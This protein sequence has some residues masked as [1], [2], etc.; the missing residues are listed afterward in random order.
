M[1]M[2]KII[3]PG[4]Q[5]LGDRTAQLIKISSSGLRGSDLN[6]L[7]KRAGHEFASAIKNMPFDKDE[8]PVHL[9][10]LGATEAVGPNRN[11]DG[12]KIASCRKYHDTFVKHS[13][14]YRNHKNKDPKKSYGI[15]KMS[16]FN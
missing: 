13:R 11:G 8:V 12:F 14:F 16:M 4:S 15:V 7:I 3:A 1:T 9:I 5:D 6:A 10:A 2:V